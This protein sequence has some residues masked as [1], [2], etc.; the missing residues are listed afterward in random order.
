MTHPIIFML[1]N[2][3]RKLKTVPHVPHKNLCMQ[4]KYAADAQ[5]A[6][7]GPKQGAALNVFA[8][9]GGQLFICGDV[10][11]AVSAPSVTLTLHAVLLLPL[12]AR[13]K[14]DLQNHCYMIRKK[15]VLFPCSRL[16]RRVIARR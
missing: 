16:K 14:M 2:A 8:A 10:E 3:T 13:L 6:Q 11:K 7:G 12:L 15:A 5:A 1:H 4:A 9:A